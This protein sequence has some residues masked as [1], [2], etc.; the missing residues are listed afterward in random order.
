M[1]WNCK[2]ANEGGRSCDLSVSEKLGKKGK[3]PRGLSTEDQ[4]KL[5]TVTGGAEANGR[6]LSIKATAQIESSTRSE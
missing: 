2:A 6:C 4:K 3:V 5:G 1:G